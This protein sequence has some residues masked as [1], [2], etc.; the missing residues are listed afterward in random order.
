MPVFTPVS[1][2]GVRWLFPCDEYLLRLLAHLNDA[3]NGHEML[4]SE[5]QWPAFDLCESSLE[6]CGEG[7]VALLQ[8]WHTFLAEILGRDDVQFLTFKLT[9]QTAF[10]RVWEVEHDGTASTLQCGGDDF[11]VVRC[12]NGALLRC[13]SGFSQDNYVIIVVDDVAGIRRLAVDVMPREGGFA[14]MHQENCGWAVARNT[15]VARSHARSSSSPMMIAGCR[16]TG[17]PGTTR[18]I[19]SIRFT[20]GCGGI[21]PRRANLAGKSGTQVQLGDVR[22]DECVAGDH[23]E[24]AVKSY[25]ARSNGTF[26]RS[27]LEGTYFDANLL[28]FDDYDMNLQLREKAYRSITIRPSRSFTTICYLHGTAFLPITALAG[29]R[30]FP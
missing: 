20:M 16:S 1:C 8:A 13:C 9:E 30:R 28:Y 29:H 19:A 23:H 15:G 22:L 7:G 18:Y 25:S 4:L 21:A 24:Q 6:F 3:G 14:I 5:G 26:R 11:I 10:R 27:A 2:Y 17:S 12:W